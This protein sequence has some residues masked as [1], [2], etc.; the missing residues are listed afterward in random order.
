M[1][2]TEPGTKSVPLQITE[3]E[4]LSNS[5]F[6]TVNVEICCHP[7]CGTHDNECSA[8]TT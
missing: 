1:A 7:L 8:L 3:G 2:T 6:A 4:Q 5:E